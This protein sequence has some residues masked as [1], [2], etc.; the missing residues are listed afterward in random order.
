MKGNTM[1]KSADGTPFSLSRRSW[2]TASASTAVLATLPAGAT[3][4]FAQ[5]RGDIAEA[6]LMK[7]GPLPDLIYGNPDAKVTVIEYASMTC[8]HCARFHNIVYPELKKKYID[9]K[10]IRFIF[11]EFPLDNLAAAA[12]MLARCTDTPQKG[13]ILTGALFKRQREWV[14]RGNPVP[15]LF[16]IAKQV[17]FTQEAFDKCLNN[18]DLLNKIAQGRD[19]ASKK[20][21]IDST[22]TFFVNGKRLQ[23]GNMAAFEAA[24]EPL[25][26]SAS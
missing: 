16:E 9:T 4:V 26:K 25:L 21:G 1:T 3:A 6:E 23:G 14:I 2:L 24:I 7:E 17:G 5:A 8:G 15:P 22:P 19:A 11:R 13:E 10:K 18:R 12:S 20:F